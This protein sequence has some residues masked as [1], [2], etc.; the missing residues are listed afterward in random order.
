ML[1]LCVLQEVQVT[2]IVASCKLQGQ[3]PMS[4]CVD[5]SDFVARGD[6]GG[7]RISSDR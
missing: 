5:L 4:K 2:P 1:D 3:R 7:T 6:F